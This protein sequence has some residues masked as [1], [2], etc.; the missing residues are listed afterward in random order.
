MVVTVQPHVE[1]AVVKKAKHPCPRISN[2]ENSRECLREISVALYLSTV[3]GP[4]KRF[5][6]TSFLNHRLLEQS[7]GIGSIDAYW[8]RVFWALLMPFPRKVA[9]LPSR[10]AHIDPMVRSDPLTSFCFFW[11]I[12]SGETICMIQRGI[13]P[14]SKG[15]GGS[16]A[17]SCSAGG[18][19]ICNNWMDY[20]FISLRF[21]IWYSMSDWN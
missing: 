13:C 2:V 4:L 1:P 10:V 8:E 9:V 3:D 12:V 21:D 7:P 18:G 17:A 20:N 16:F 6:E 14:I 15:R 5:P 11:W 19:G